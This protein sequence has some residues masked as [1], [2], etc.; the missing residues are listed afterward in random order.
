[1]SKSSFLEFDTDDA[2]KDELI[3]ILIMI[4]EKYKV[5]ISVIGDFTGIEKKLN[6]N[7]FIKGQEYQNNIMVLVLE[8]QTKN[9]IFTKIINKLKIINI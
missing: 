6:F 2:I 5:N 9:E 4:K 8:L 7:K 3:P 1:M